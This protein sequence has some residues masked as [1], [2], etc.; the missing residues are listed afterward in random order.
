M[1]FSERRI[2]AVGPRVASLQSRR[3]EL[4]AQANEAG[5]LVYGDE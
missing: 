2:E 4:A 3:T 1:R 5:I